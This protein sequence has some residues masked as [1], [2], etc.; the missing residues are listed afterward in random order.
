MS[1]QN[2]KVG[3]TSQLILRSQNYP[4]TK[5]RQRQQ[6]HHK[7][8]KLKAQISDEH[9]CKNPQQ[10]TSKIYKQLIQ[11]NTIKTNNLIK[12][13]ADLNRHFSKKPYRWPTGTRKD[14]LHR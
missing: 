6:R 8:R 12:K 9:K 5:P 10:Y 14:V 1:P 3:N 13:G 4:D 2:G 7:R 11:L